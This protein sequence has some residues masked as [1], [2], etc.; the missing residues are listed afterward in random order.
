MRNA[1][2]VEDEG[3]EF[4]PRYITVSNYLW[5]PKLGISF[6]DAE[7]LEGSNSSWQFHGNLWVFLVG[8]ASCI[9]THIC[10][11]SKHCLWEVGPD[12]LRSWPWHFNFLFF[13]DQ[14]SSRRSKLE[15]KF[16]QMEMDKDHK[17]LKATAST[18]D[19]GQNVRQ[20][21]TK[22]PGRRLWIAHREIKPIWII[23]ISS[24]GHVL[25]QNL[26]GY[27]LSFSP[28]SMHL[29]IRRGLTGG[30]FPKL[31]RQSPPQGR[32]PKPTLLK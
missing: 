5:D 18:F 17:K 19:L 27:R 32:S 16:R 6:G 8:C 26:L 13:T 31:S 9:N 1:F 23:G 15:A 21:A 2:E 25:L 7:S 24:R 11:T 30:R 10:C 3:E 4:V 28:V 20:L 12:I 22:R 14:M 29:N